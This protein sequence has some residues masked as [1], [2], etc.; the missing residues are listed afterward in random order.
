MS[1]TQRPA[2]V[3]HPTTNARLPHDCGSSCFPI[4]PNNLLLEV[5]ATEMSRIPQP[6]VRLSAPAPHRRSSNR[7]SYQTNPNHPQ[8][9]K[10]FRMRLT[11]MMLWFLRAPLM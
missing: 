3:T 10:S 7:E 9:S 2:P 5:K 8:Y 6:P 1:H 4:G 11:L